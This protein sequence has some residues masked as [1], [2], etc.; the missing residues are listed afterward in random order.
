MASL[1]PLHL[2]RMGAPAAV[3]VKQARSEAQDDDRGQPRSFED[4]FNDDI[5]TEVDRY[6]TGNDEDV[7]SLCMWVTAWC[8]AKGKKCTDDTYRKA[9]GAFGFVPERGT[10]PLPPFPPSSSGGWRTLFL[11]LCGAF[12]MTT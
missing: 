6:L 3:G 1:P 12:Q 2:L 4:I 5:L 10:Q 11:N 7:A 8:I 9:I